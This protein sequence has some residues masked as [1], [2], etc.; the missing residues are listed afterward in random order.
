MGITLEVLPAGSQILH[1][2]A[3]DI[4]YKASEQEINGVRITLQTGNHRYDSRLL[5]LLTGSHEG[6][7]VGG[8]LLRIKA[9][10]LEEGLIVVDAET[11]GCQRN[12]MNR[13]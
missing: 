7:E 1:I 4:C 13:L 12:H 8:S 5:E 2:V 10:L 3:V 6:I 11:L 9:G